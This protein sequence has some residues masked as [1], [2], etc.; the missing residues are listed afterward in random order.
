MVYDSLSLSAVVGVCL[1]S[2]EGTLTKRGKKGSVPAKSE[3]RIELETMDQ[4]LT[5]RTTGV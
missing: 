1:K 5:G 2:T 3:E 4:P